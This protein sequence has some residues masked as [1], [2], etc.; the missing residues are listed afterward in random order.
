MPASR[1]SALSTLRSATAIV[2]PA[3]GPSFGATAMVSMPP[4]LR[5]SL[6]GN[7]NARLPIGVD[8]AKPGSG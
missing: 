2:A 8:A 4:L 3:R 6:I 7:G 5:N 1:L